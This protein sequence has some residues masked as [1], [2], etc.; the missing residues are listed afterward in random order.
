MRANGVLIAFVSVVSLVACAPEAPIEPVGLD[1]DLAPC[2]G[3]IDSAGIGDR[4]GGNAPVVSTCR[5]TLN[6][7]VADAAVN[8]C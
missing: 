6:A 7:S 5:D 8:S 1:I 2:L 3:A 4:D